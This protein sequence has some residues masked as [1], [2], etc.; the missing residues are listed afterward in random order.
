MLKTSGKC[1]IVCVGISTETH[2]STHTH[3]MHNSAFGVLLCFPHSSVLGQ[4]CKSNPRGRVWGQQLL[5]GSHPSV[6][7]PC[8]LSLG[9]HNWA[10]SSKIYCTSSFLLAVCPIFLCFDLKHLHQQGWHKI[11]RTLKDVWAIEAEWDAKIFNKTIA[12]I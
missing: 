3:F 11:C 6:P 8:Q 5:K 9:Y 10:Q 7:P 1:S 2:P 4:Q 12:V